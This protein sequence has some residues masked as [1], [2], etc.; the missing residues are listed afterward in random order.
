MIN[1]NFSVKYPQQAAIAS[2]LSD[3]SY[4]S[5]TYQMQNKLA[6]STIPEVNVSTP[7][8]KE[9]SIQFPKIEKNIECQLKSIGDKFN[10]LEKNLDMYQQLIDPMK[11]HL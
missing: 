11:D 10:K 7:D 6:D 4:Y 9:S 8:K 3:K 5:R 1:A 2:A